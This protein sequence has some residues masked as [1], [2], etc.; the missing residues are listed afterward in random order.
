MRW[1]MRIWDYDQWLERVLEGETK[2]VAASA[3]CRQHSWLESR[4]QEIISNMTACD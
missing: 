1:K 4:K 3:F 2:E